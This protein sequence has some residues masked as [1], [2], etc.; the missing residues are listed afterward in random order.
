MTGRFATLKPLLLSL[1]FCAT[2]AVTAAPALAVPHAGDPVPPFTLP[3]PGGATVGSANFK[4][5]PL[6]VN[7]FASWCGPCN[8]EAPDIA[9]L[10]RTYH[11]RGLAIVGVDE[12]EESAKAAE[13]ARKYAWPFAV[14][15]DADGTMGR[16]FGAV[17][18]P[19]HVFVDRHGHVS[20]YRLGEMSPPEIE[21]AIKKIL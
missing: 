21:D 18:L 12:L 19:V 2:A 7:F 15:V 10:Y 5:K 3:K 14:G 8:L 11:K 20:T 9:R 17:G 13:F 16:D 4:G 1:I 6:Y